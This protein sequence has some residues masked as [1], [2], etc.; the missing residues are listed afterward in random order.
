MQIIPVC[1]G[2]DCN[3]PLYRVAR[4]AR[5]MDDTPNF[6]ETMSADGGILW[7]K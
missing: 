1:W 6:E 2:L 5:G 4:R 7:K 3:S